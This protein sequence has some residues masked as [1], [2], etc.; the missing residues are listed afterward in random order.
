MAGFTLGR[1][2]ESNVSEFEPSD[3]VEGDG[4]WQD[5]FCLPGKRLRKRSPRYR[6]SLRDRI[7][8]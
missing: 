4:G 3:L 1:V 2:I 8:S 5:Y 6:N 7:N